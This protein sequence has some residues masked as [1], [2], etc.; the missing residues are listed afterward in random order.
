LL[1]KLAAE[2]LKNILFEATAL[3]SRVLPVPGGPK[4]SI[5]RVAFLI[6]LKN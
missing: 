6:P 2:T 3:A 4:S 5:P 1:A